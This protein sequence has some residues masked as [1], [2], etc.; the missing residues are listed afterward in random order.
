M[1]EMSLEW[2]IIYIRGLDLGTPHLFD[3]Q[4]S[5][6]VC[7]HG[8]VIPQDSLPCHMQSSH[9]SAIHSVADLGFLSP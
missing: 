9:K 6:S 7:L 1:V 2:H 3:A 4:M 8:T 5:L